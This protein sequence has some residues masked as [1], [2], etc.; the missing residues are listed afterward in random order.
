MRPQNVGKERLR[1]DITTVL[2]VGY[3]LVAIVVGVV[4][5]YRH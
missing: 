3:S 1:M 4:I 5:S 2:V